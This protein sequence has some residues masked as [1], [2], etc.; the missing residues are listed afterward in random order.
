MCPI[1][2]LSHGLVPYPHSLY[3]VTRL[4]TTGT[5]RRYLLGDIDVLGQ[6]HFALLDRARQI[7]LLHRLAQIRFLVDQSNESI[8]DLK[9]HLGALV[10][11]VFQLARGCDG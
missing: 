11:R 4:G 7:C 9:V 5:Y 10:D 3:H 2:R 8:F 1:V 6:R